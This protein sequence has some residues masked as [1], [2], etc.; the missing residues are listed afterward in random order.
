MHDLTRE[1]L[2]DGQ[3]HDIRSRCHVGDDAAD[4]RAGQ[5]AWFGAEAEHDL[6]TVDGVDDNALGLNAIDLPSPSLPI[7]TGATAVGPV[8]GGSTA[9]R[10]ADPTA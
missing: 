1:E 6:V 5:P 4:L 10:T 3:P 9:S 2:G 8:W 7:L